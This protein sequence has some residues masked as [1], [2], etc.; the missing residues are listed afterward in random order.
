MNAPISTWIFKL[1][2][3]EIFATSNLYSFLDYLMNQGTSELMNA[4]MV[5]VSHRYLMT[6]LSLKIVYLWRH[7]SSTAPP[8]ILWWWNL[9]ILYLPPS[10]VKLFKWNTL[11]YSKDPKR[12]QS[13]VYIVR[14]LWCILLFL[15]TFLSYSNI[16][17]MNYSEE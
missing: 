5:N 8:F 10:T 7:V 4:C 9:E 15:L 12:T 2:S 14:C 13:A 11:L 3:R 6:R 16:N 17:S 1:S